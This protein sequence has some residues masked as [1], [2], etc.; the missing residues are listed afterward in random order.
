MA[1]VGRVVEPLSGADRPTDRLNRVPD[2]CLDPTIYY[3]AAG[4]LCVCLA[5][6]VDYA[7]AELIQV[8]HASPLSD[9]VANRS[10]YVARV[11]GKCIYRRIEIG[12]IIATLSSPAAQS[13]CVNRSFIC[14][15]SV[16]LELEY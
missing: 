14:T 10:H 6:L 15:T 1:S 3:S 2:N 13:V 8:W 5:T 11:Y 16:W 12:V 4:R 9:L 7:T